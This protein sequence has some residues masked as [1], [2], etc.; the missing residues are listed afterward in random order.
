MVSIIGAKYSGHDAGIFLLEK[1]NEP[2]GLDK[3]RI[4]RQKHDINFPY[5]CLEFVSNKLKGQNV[6][7]AFSDSNVSLKSTVKECDKNFHIKDYLS[8]RKENI[9]EKTVKDNFTY[10]IASK[11]YR[12]KLVR[13]FDNYLTKNY[14]KKKVKS[15]LPNSKLIDVERYDHHLCHAAAAYH[16]SN[17][18][19]AL[20]ITLDGWGDYY[21]SRVFLCDDK[22]RYITGTR[23]EDSIG[24]TYTSFTEALGL[25]PNSDEGK[26]EALAAYGARD[27]DL[28]KKLREEIIVEGLKIKIKNKNLVKR[29]LWEVEKV[30]KPLVQKYGDKDSAAAIQQVLEETGVKLIQNAVDEFGIKYLCFSGGVFANVI[31]NLKIFEEVKPK[32]MYII[33]AMSDSGTSQGAVVLSALKHGFN[34]SNFTKSEMPYYGPEYNEDSIKSAIEK[35]KDKIKVQISEDWTKHAAELIE[36]GNVIGIYHGKM[37]YGPR[38]L[39]NR[40]ILADPRDIKVK[41][42]INHTIKRRVWYQPFCPSVLESERQRLFENSYKHKHMAIAFYVKEKYRD[43]IPAIMHID[44]TARP[45]FVEKKDNPNYF[46]LLSRFKKLTN[47]GILLN[48]SFNLHGRTIVMTP[49]DALQ[50][51]IDCGLDYLFLE[52]YLIKVK[53]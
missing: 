16:F 48:T 17:F 30:F 45:Q 7:V 18:K 10:K 5:E 41:D 38:A 37:E 44:G 20:S 22:I 26:V 12:S 8:W 42:V 19:K 52:K 23:G 50:D 21:C 31:M 29:E 1:E 6:V 36:K 4:T 51:F 2:F 40:S 53:K 24:Q 49:E 15:C 13:P 25:T 27:N 9:G 28:Y 43:K 33:P 35:F 34:I 47:Y 32:N 46:S 3:E 14:L 39:G 11:I